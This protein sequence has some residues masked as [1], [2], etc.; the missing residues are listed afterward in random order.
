MPKGSPFVSEKTSRLLGRHWRKCKPTWTVPRKRREISTAV[1][2][3]PTERGLRIP[4]SLKP[5]PATGE[6]TDP[7]WKTRVRA[8]NCFL[9]EY[10]CLQ[11]RSR[12]HTRIYLDGTPV[13]RKYPRVRK[14]QDILQRDLRLDRRLPFPTRKVFFTSPNGGSKELLLAASKK[15]KR[16][17][18][19][20]KRLQ[21]LFRFILIETDY[22]PLGLAPSVQF[23][24]GLVLITG[25]PPLCLLGE[26]ITM[27]M[28]TR[29]SFEKLSIHK[30]YSLMRDVRF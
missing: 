19:F 23:R 14:K 28:N 17:L 29:N 11:A 9:R 26:V 4:R 25:T 20:S 27:V 16:S 7:H 22:I 18:E 3:R 2:P 13:D 30:L 24:G 5:D 6:H 12:P 10:R 8:E 21:R 15:S 1:R